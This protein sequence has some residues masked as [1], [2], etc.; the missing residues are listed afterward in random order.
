MT[1]S[2]NLYGLYKIGSP[3]FQLTVIN[4]Y[5]ALELMHKTIHKTIHKCI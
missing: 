1:N 3:M 5:K 4:A 2:L